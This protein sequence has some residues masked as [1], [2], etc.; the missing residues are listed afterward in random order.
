MNRWEP[1]LKAVK[2][3]IYK[4]QE[5]YKFEYIETTL[6]AVNI[7][8][9]YDSLH[10]TQMA[11]TICFSRHRSSKKIREVYMGF[12]LEDNVPSFD[13]QKVLS[14]PFKDNPPELILPLRNTPKVEIIQRL[15]EEYFRLCFGCRQ[16]SADGTPCGR[17]TTCRLIKKN[18]TNEKF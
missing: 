8:M 10:T 6:D 11:A 1:E 5:K 12:I 18:K 13:Y 17:C 7:G 2:N 14:A 4:F 9:T 15:P 16:P 3:L